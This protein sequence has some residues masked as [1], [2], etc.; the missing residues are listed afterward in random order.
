M[1][2][3]SDELDGAALRT[4]VEVLTELGLHPVADIAR[5]FVA[6]TL[7]GHAVEFAVTGAAAVDATRAASLAGRPMPPTTVPLVVGDRLL[8]PARAVL[9]DR[10]WS[11]IDRRGGCHL[12][13]PGLLVHTDTAPHSRPTRPRS[14]VDLLGSR[15]TQDEPPVLR[16]IA[17]QT[18][19]SPS[20]VSRSVA[21]LRAAGLVRRD[22]RAV[23]PDLF[24]AL[25]ERWPTERK[26][27]ATRPEPV[28]PPPTGSATDASVVLGD[29]RA[30][31][32]WRAPL[33]ASA[34]APPLLYVADERQ[35][36]RMLTRHGEVS[37]S[38]AGAAAWVAVAPV[39]AL[40]ERAV[41][42]PEEAWP[43]AHP[44]FVALDLAG[45]RARGHQILEEWDPEDVDRVW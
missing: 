42:R 44:L 14:T 43:V 11:W 8:T 30:A 19:L 27:L 12:R 9:E 28:G 3:T 6:V 31:L 17:R 4:T 40:L 2:E 37:G 16:E 1:R 21:G 20:T 45:D 5:A 38:G 24:W 41:A 32:A 15:G 23:L 29:T 26:G 22:G 35:R 33:I 25:A 34:D 36:Q 13:G 7:D 39:R 10:G 18:G